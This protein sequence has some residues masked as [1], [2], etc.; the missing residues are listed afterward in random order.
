MDTGS[1]DVNRTYRIGEI[2]NLAH[3]SLR[4]LRYWE[5]VGLLAPADRTEGGFRLY[6]QADLERVMLV[7][8]M[9]P[10][11][12]SIEELKELVRLVDRVRERRHDDPDGTEGSTR[13]LEQFVVRIRSRCEVVRNRLVAAE[14]A[15]VEIE[16]LME[17]G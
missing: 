7:R 12:I 5:E 13:A 9:K 4:T 8:A 2:A 17:G 15:A 14:M 11:D 3:L 16:L 10:I 1:R 6:S